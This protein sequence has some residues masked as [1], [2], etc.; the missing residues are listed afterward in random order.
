[1]ICQKSLMFYLWSCEV[2]QLVANCVSQKAKDFNKIAILTFAS[3]V[4]L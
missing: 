1:M 3:P 2:L 4:H